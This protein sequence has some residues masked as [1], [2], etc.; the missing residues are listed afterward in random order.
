MS[1]EERDVLVKRWRRQLFREA[2][3][4]CCIVEIITSDEIAEA[5]GAAAAMGTTAGAWGT[6]GEGGP[7]WVEPK[8]FGMRSSKR[9]RRQSRKKT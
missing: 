7:G 9:K 5:S 6:P 1:R 3:L 8:G 4:R 2:L